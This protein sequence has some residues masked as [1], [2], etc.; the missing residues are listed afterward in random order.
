M[1]KDENEKMKSRALN[2]VSFSR[3]VRDMIF[4][5]WTK[6]TRGIW[7][8]LIQFYWQYG[9]LDMKCF[10]LPYPICL[11][12]SSFFLQQKIAEEKSPTAAVARRSECS[13]PHLDKLEDLLADG[14]V[15]A[16]DCQAEMSDT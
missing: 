5:V 10:L 16:G 12:S 14:D 9:K 8:F 4:S 7:Q 15:V 2:Q 6:L 3:K 1:D 11:K 13:L